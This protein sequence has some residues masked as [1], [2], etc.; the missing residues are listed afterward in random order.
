MTI[1]E[2]RAITDE[3]KYLDWVLLIEDIDHSMHL[4]WAFHDDN[5]VLWHSRKWLLSEHMT[6][7]EIVQTALKAV[8]TAAEHEAREKFKY[9]GHAVFGPHISVERLLEACV[10]L[11]VRG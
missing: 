9:K 10:E 5:G 6:R 2:I 11:E 7:S 8:L 3:I 4:K 1:A